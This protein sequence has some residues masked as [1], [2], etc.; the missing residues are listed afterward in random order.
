MIPRSLLRL[1]VVLVVMAVWMPSH[2]A[3]PVIS[4]H[5]RLL[6]SDDTPLADGAYAATFSLWTDSVG[7]AQLWSEPQDI[8]T[9]DGLFSAELGLT[10]GFF[11]VFTDF[12]QQD[13]YLE[14]QVLVSGSPETLRPRLRLGAVPSAF[15][16]SSV[17][18]QATNGLARWRG[19]VVAKPGSVTPHSFVLLDV[20]SDADGTP[21]VEI[22]DA[23]TENGATSRWKGGMSGSTTGTI[24]MAATPD[25]VV[26]ACDVGDGSSSSSINMRTRINEL[27]SKLLHL[28][29]M[30]NSSVTTT[31]DDLGARKVVVA[32]V[33][34]DGSP[35]RIVSSS[36]DAT[37]AK[38]AVN[39]KGTGAQSGRLVFVSG[40]TGEGSAVHTCAIDDDG[41]GLPDQEVA[42]A[43]VPTTSSV[44]INTKGT[45]AD[46]NR[47]AVTGTTTLDSAAIACTHDTDDDG[48]PEGSASVVITPTTSNVAINTKGTGADKNR[49][50]STTYQDSAVQVVGADLDGDGIFNGTVWQ[51]VD[52]SETAMAMVV[53]VDDDGTPDVGSSS[54]AT[55]SRSILKTFFERGDRPTQSQIVDSADEA[56][57][58]MAIKT[59]GTG[60]Q[61]MVA[62]ATDASTA[63]T[64]CAVDLNNDGTDDYSATTTSSSTSTEYKLQSGFI[65]ATQ[66]SSARI[67]V[68]SAA[69]PSISLEQN[70]T[71]IHVMNGD[72]S[73]LR[74]SVGTVAAQIG[75]NGE[76]YFQSKVGIGVAAP[77]AAIEVAGGAYCNGTNWVNVSDADIKENFQPVDG[78]KI[79]EKIEQ[80]RITQW[81]YKNESDEV[82]HIGPTA[83]DFKEV[84][85]V[86]ANDKTISTID[87]SGIALAAVKELRKENQ[88]L[89]AQVAELKKLIEEIA[90]KK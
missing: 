27:E 90:S 33:D 9:K 57:A 10:N 44:A 74:N 68:D 59:K 16:A 42:S 69:G 70:G 64:V 41:D 36:C 71:V 65:Y 20:D 79:L 15:S 29:L 7:G 30:Q 4:H 78:E 48:D 40:S 55:Q 8:E 38:H 13:L 22:E 51:K 83:Q 1:V 39:T 53:D 2:A 75:T 6:N 62:S 37:S 89:K 46:K 49:I 25:S 31:C 82:T 52:S 28:G 32:D 61:R 76:A 34:R 67:V 63:S 87:P 80:L 85:G 19:M 24:R 60:A 66:P 54:N 12:A 18:G 26:Q 84:F 5:G 86:G 3:T 56:G 17:N 72:G 35:D 23:V 45:G 73:I 43:V 77:S 88:E 47:V 81:N 21:E 50:S 14:V 58:R 11:D